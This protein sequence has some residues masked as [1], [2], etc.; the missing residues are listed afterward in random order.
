[1]TSLAPGLLG[2]ARVEPFPGPPPAPPAPPGEMPD[3]RKVSPRAPTEPPPSNKLPAIGSTPHGA[4]TPEHKDTPRSNIYRRWGGNLDAVHAEEIQR[5]GSQRDHHSHVNLHSQASEWQRRLR[6]EQRAR[7]RAGETGGV[8][9]ATQQARL[10]AFQCLRD[11]L[12]SEDSPRI[13]MELELGAFGSVGMTVSSRPHTPAEEVAMRD[14]VVDQGLT[15]HDL[16]VLSDASVAGPAKKPEDMTKEEVISW[17]RDSGQRTKFDDVLNILEFH[18]VRAEFEAA[19]AAYPNFD[20]DADENLSNDDDSSVDPTS[21]R[22]RDVPPS[23]AK[24][25]RVSS[26][27]ASPNKSRDLSPKPPTGSRGGSFRTAKQ[28]AALSAK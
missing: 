3:T 4:P 23:L 14:W 20:E 22:S 15:S 25:V 18:G 19:C 7:L 24:R 5:N 27:D 21:T 11:A 8:A 10:N 28:V 13:Q 2:R 17:L 12:G 9:H 6:H 16:Q 1:M 26:R